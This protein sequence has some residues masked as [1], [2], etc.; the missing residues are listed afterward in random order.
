LLH[1][2]VSESQ[3]GVPGT[4]LTNW[5]ALRRGLEAVRYQGLVVIESF[6]PENRDLAG[7]VCIWKRR[8][9]DQD[10]FARQGLAFLRSSLA[11]S[12]P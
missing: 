4:G 12:S 11:S 8:A 7:A 2:Q 5:A 10:T 3:R 1:V 6:T 9:P